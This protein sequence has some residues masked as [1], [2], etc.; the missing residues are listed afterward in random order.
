MAESRHARIIE[1]EL[2]P[3][4]PCVNIVGTGPYRFIAYDKRYL[5]GKSARWVVVRQPF[6]GQPQDVLS[7]YVNG[8]DPVKGKPFAQEIVDGLTVPPSAEESM[9]GLPAT[10][11][12]PPTLTD[13]E[14][15]LQE[16]FKRNDWTDY[17]PII[18]PTE[19]RVEAMLAGTK[20]KPT[21]MVSRNDM[22]PGARQC[23]VKNVAIAAVMAGAKPSMFP[24][25]L[26]ATASGTLALSSV[27]FTNAIFVGGPIRNE[28]KMNYKVGALGPWNE[29]NAILGRAFLLL[30]KT[31]TGVHV[32][33]TEYFESG[34]SPES[35]G[36]NL[37]YNSVVT[38]ENEE[39]LPPGW[40]PLV[41]QLGFKPGE[42]VVAVG[43]GDTM[44]HSSG[45]MTSYN[46]AQMMV[47]Y[48]HGLAG[49]GAVTIY[50]DPTVARM[51]HDSY[52]FESKEQLSQYFCGNFQM[53][54]DQYWSNGVHY[55]TV[56]GL[57]KQ[58]L[59]PYASWVK[60]FQDGNKTMLIKPYT[61]PR[62]VRIVVVG[63][64][65]QSTFYVT[66]FRIGR[67]IK[68]SDWK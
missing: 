44:I 24:T 36:N 63:G 35:Q 59:E 13:T 22:L 57:G 15:N 18:L 5:S 26:S 68:V 9:T 65:T 42:S 47:D 34:T 28:L 30:G 17:A 56:W 11:A 6:A 2:K 67:G 20:R 51:L 10:K 8:N 40:T 3:G 43:T 25:I 60:A 27:S 46:P 55:S 12:V 14:E 64:E 50:M 37:Q 7:A 23:T 58:G 19:Q 61:N 31:A 53:T 48:A 1:N 39:A 62:D 52:G 4:K 45:E 32:Y 38:V 21:D 16:L 54:V 49:G 66:N 29:T 33:P 41:Q